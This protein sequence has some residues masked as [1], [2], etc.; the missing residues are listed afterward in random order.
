MRAA[1]W[2]AIG[3]VAA[4]PAAA[5]SAATQ[6]GEPKRLRGPL[7]Q[8]WQQATEMAV[9]SVGEEES[10]QLVMLAYGSA[11]GRS[12][13]GFELDEERYRAAFRMLAEERRGDLEDAKRARSLLRRTSYHLGVAT[14]IFLAEHA[15]DPARFCA[16]ARESLADPE[17]ADFFVRAPAP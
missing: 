12:C 6:P 11:V 9:D 1:R 5:A 7:E 14:G 17:I 16:G 15:L 2:T 4:L 10:G 13:E 3:L 8:A